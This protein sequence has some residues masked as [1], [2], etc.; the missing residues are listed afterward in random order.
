MMLTMR[1]EQCGVAGVAHHLAELLCVDPVE[2]E[3]VIF[4][5]LIVIDI[6]VAGGGVASLSRSLLLLILN[7]DKS[8]FIVLFILIHEDVVLMVVACSSSAEG[9]PGSARIS[10]LLPCGVREQL[11]TVGVHSSVHRF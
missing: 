9:L 2:A 7:T 10:T 1:G 11:G 4:V 6:D 8:V 3:L 5:V